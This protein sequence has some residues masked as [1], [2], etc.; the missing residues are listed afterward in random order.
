M[1]YIR[2]MP[3]ISAV[4]GKSLTLKC[5]AAG[6]PIDS[7]VWEKG[8]KLTTLTLVVLHLFTILMMNR[9]YKIT[10]QHVTTCLQWNTSY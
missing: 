4:A 2:P 6:Y 1:P 8:K 9:W 10:D 5:P 7:I 3:S